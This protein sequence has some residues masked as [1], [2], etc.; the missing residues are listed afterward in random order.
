MIDQAPGMTARSFDSVSGSLQNLRDVHM[1]EAVSMWWPPAI[2]WFI[3]ASI[4]LCL[5]VLGVYY[6]FCTWER[7]RIRRE[8]IGYLNELAAECEN[9]NDQHYATACASIIRRVAIAYFKRENVASLY[10][11]A[12][13]S[14][15]CHYHRD[16]NQYEQFAILV[17]SP[18]ESSVELDRNALRNACVQ[19]VK[20]LPLTKYSEKQC[21]N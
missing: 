1:P 8:A 5:M 13:L 10:G 3:L 19:W 11:E 2:G 4:L 16:K 15:L 12:W 20:Q 7:R 18:Y 21:L 14:F 17:R 9:E 6:I